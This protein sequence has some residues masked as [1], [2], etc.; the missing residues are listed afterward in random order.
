MNNAKYEQEPVSPSLSLLEAM[1]E[2]DVVRQRGHIPSR[3]TVA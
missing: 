3:C 1:Y 2:D